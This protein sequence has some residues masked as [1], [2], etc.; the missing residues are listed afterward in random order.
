M[1]VLK[2]LS[3]YP[4]WGS[5]IKRRK[6]LEHLALKASEAQ[7]QELQRSGKNTDSSLTQGKAVT[8]WEPEPNLSTGFG[9]YP[10][11][12]G[13]WLRPS[14]RSRTLVVEAPWIY[15]LV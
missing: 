2:L 12:G 10:R 14:A 11:V 5:G 13:G 8:P 1:R 3:D 9:Q 15:S 6:S 7:V 4:A